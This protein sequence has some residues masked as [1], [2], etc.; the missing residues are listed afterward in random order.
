MLPLSLISGIRNPALVQNHLCTLSRKQYNQHVLLK[1]VIS[2]TE[3][4][5]SMSMIFV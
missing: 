1:S 5:I 4:P 2:V 3:I